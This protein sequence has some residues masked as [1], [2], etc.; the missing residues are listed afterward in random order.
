[1]RYDLLFLDL[2]GTLIHSGPDIADSTNAVMREF[3]LPEFREP[4]VIAAIGGGISTLVDRLLGASHPERCPAAVARI[5][6]VYG[7]RLLVRTTLYPGVRETLA[8]LEAACV[9]VTNKPEHM[10]RKILAGL[11]LEERFARVYGADTLPV[12]KPDPAALRES[13]AALEV[14]AARSLMV[15]DSDVDHATAR[16]AGVDFCG[17][18]YGYG[19]DGDLDG[20]AHR[21]DRFEQ[22]VDVV[23]GRR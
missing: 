17:V 21:I 19:K 14:P 10:T 8:A 2:D 4:E 23:L 9:I 5:R 12:H 3:G 18:T 13:L 6:E 15:G 1:M 20:A 11:R 16:N 7:T 22:L